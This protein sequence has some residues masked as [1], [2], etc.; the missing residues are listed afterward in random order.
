M[1][2]DLESIIRSVWLFRNIPQGYVKEIA[3]F[4]KLEVFGIGQTII[5]KSEPPGD[6]YILVEGSA[7][8]I[9]NGGDAKTVL[10]SLGPGEYFGEMSILTGEPASA[11][12]IAVEKCKVLAI[13]QEA[14]ARI[15]LLVPE[16][17]HDLLRT[18]VLR[19]RDGNLRVLEARNRMRALTGLL[20]DEKKGKYSQIIGKSK[21]TQAV[22]ENIP[23]W[24]ASHDLLYMVGEKGTGKELLARAIH[25][26]SGRKMK[27][28]IAV[29]CRNLMKEELEVKLFGR[30]GYLELANEGTLFLKDAEVLNFHNLKRLLDLINSRLIDVRVIFATKRDFS[31]RL[32][33]AGFSQCLTH[34]IH[35]SPLRKRK[36]DIPELIQYFL[37]ELSQKYN[38]PVPIVSKGAM[39]KLL[40]YDY[41]I[42]NVAELEEVLERAVLLSE[43]NQIL[44][45]H[46]FLGKV[47]GKTGHG[48][49]L[50]RCPPVLSLIKKRVYP[51]IPEYA[52]T[53][54]FLLVWMVCLGGP[55]AWQKWA[56]LGAWSI[57]WPLLIIAAAILGRTACSLCPISCVAIGFR[58]IV[59]LSKPIPILL[60]KYDYLIVTFFS[61]FIFW[62]E[63]FTNMRNSP[64]GTGV[65]L[66]CIVLGAV[67][68]AAFFQRQ[69]WCSYLC[70]L[71]GILGICSMV[72]IIELRSNTE[73]CLN[74]CTTHDCYKGSDTAAGCPLFQHVPFIDN[75]QL[76]KLCFQCVRNCPNDAVQLLLRPP[77]REI[78]HL[79]RVNRGKVIFVAA[80]LVIIFPL[81]V[82]DSL[83]AILSPAVWA[84]WFSLIYWLSV[85]STVGLSWFIVKSKLTD[86]RF[87]PV[88]RAFYAFVPLAV[89]AH[90]AYQ[91]KFLPVVPQLALYVYRSLHG[92]P[93]AVLGLGLLDALMFAAMVIGLLLSLICAWKIRQRMISKPRFFWVKQAIVM[94]TYFCL[95]NYTFFFCFSSRS[96]G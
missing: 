27:P 61:V 96:F 74:K 28:F 19:L 22:I 38:Q 13:P 94:I 92:S 73:V 77:A 91:I 20:N 58:R 46:I 87:L 64:R 57:G 53:S 54:V 75:S 31:D 10:A 36:R 55:A 69:T 86:D 62:I 43:N 40:S 89:G 95:L 80:L 49:N 4:C 56:T 14:F 85:L 50:L 33:S 41:Y 35:V 65:L 29:E 88:I 47:A 63:E 7:Q 48:I 51:S 25:A 18:M 2:E 45:E 78:W 26:A 32:S 81:A 11:E 60:K 52:V 70:P 23:R 93:T 37:A 59:H 90:I 17:N 82:F 21:D 34:V 3:R 24:A 68:S 15:S 72:S 44:F 79:T 67:L 8:V 1:M 84:G 30:F 66:S 12:I 39:E 6:F 5:A 9:L 76:C 71:G 16:L 83:R 42:G